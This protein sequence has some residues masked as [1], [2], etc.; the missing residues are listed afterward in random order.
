MF[1]SCRLSQKWSFKNTSLL[2]HTEIPLACCN[3]NKYPAP[4]NSSPHFGLL[5]QIRN[6]ASKL[7]METPYVIALEL[8]FGSLQFGYNMLSSRFK[9]YLCSKPFI[10]SSCSSSQVFLAMKFHPNERQGSYIPKSSTFVKEFWHYTFFF[11]Q[12]YNLIFHN[13]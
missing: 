5:W 3:H 7:I 12:L 13:R 6:L 4:L 8:V 9:S 11:T 1:S 2:T 10:C